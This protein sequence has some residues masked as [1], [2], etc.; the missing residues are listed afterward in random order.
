M[1]ETM[2]GIFIFLSSAWLTG[3]VEEEVTIIKYVGE[4]V[5]CHAPGHV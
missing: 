1:K 2:F 5:K 4:I 3:I